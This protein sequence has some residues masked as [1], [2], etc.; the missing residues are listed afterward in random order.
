M[1][2]EIA[3]NT[4]AEFVQVLLGTQFSELNRDK[5]CN[6]RIPEDLPKILQEIEVN[7]TPLQSLHKLAVISFGSDTERQPRFARFYSFSNRN[8][9]NSSISSSITNPKLE[10]GPHYSMTMTARTNLVSSNSSMPFPAISWDLLSRKKIKMSVRIFWPKS[11]RICS[12]FTIS[13][14]KSQSLLSFE[15]I[16]GIVS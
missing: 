14:R 8:T 13:K 12:V 10:I 3:P 11:A 4:P 9:K 16:I 7:K 15:V 2:P 6:I 5:A 1:I